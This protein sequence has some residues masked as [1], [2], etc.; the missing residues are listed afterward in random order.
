M[1]VATACIRQPP[2]CPPATGRYTICLPLNRTAWLEPPRRSLPHGDDVRELALGLT[3]IS[4]AFTVVACAATQPRT[5]VPAP[6][7][8][9]PIVEHEAQPVQSQGSGLS[10]A[11]EPA[12][13]VILIDGTPAGKV[14][15]LDSTHGF[16][17]V[18]PGIYQVSLKCK[19]F[20]TWRAEVTVG[21]GTEAI[22]VT[23]GMSP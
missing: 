23:M 21:E 15:D 2:A 6:V 7:Q 17:K 5:L 8:P 20:V 16:L 4:L 10:F 12:D 3:V 19:G 18:K 13:A 14:R 9:A 1:S 11:V 22:H